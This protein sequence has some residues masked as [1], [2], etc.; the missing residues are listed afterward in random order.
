M[1]QRTEILKSV[2][3]PELAIIVHKSSNDE[4]YLE[5]HNINEK[6]QVLEGKPLLQETIQGVVDMFLDNRSEITNVG[7]IIPEKLILF[8]VLPGGNYKI[9]WY[10]P[11]EL[12][13]LYFDDPLKIKNGKAYSPALLYVAD[14]KNMSVFALKSNDR[15]KSTTPLFRAPFHNVNDNG[16][17]CLGNA[18]VKKP[19][20]MT[21]QNIMKYWED[22]FWL[23]EFSH[24]NG[25]TMPTTKPLDTIWR[26]LIKG[27]DKKKFPLS[28]MKPS[29]VDI[30]TF[31]K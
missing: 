31:L 25:A 29:K 8:M 12:R 14:S 15:P 11:A 20:L 27:K 10:R 22:L 19:T 30:K 6:G 18:D 13:Q 28:V 4:F 26:T 9:A 24:L 16:A 5:S 23:S 7:G 1:N 3:K 21:Y 2:F 17:V